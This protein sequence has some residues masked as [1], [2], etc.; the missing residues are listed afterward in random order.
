MEFY[1]EDRSLVV[2][3]HQGYKCTRCGVG[4]LKVKEADASMAKMEAL[5]QAV[6]KMTFTGQSMECPNPECESV[7]TFTESVDYK[8][9]IGGVTHVTSNPGYICSICGTQV[10]DPEQAKQHDS[11]V[12]ELVRKKA[13]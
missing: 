6:E 9:K 4:F 13:S 11:Q 2:S 7:C 1:V 5:R 8:T 3:Q 12:R 10:Y